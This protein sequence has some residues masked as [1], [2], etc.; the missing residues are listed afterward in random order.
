MDQVHRHA[1]DVDCQQAAPGKFINAHEEGRRVHDAAIDEKGHQESVNAQGQAFC[2]EQAFLV[3][4]PREKPDQSHGEHLPR[5]PRPL[6]KEEVADQHRDCPHQESGFAPKG[7]AADDDDG[8]D[9]FEA[10]HH[11][12]SCPSRTGQ[13]CHGRQDDHLPCLGFSPLKY[14]EERDQR[15]D[16]DHHADE[17]VDPASENGLQEGTRIVGG[18]P[19]SDDPDGDGD[20]DHHKQEE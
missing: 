3:E 20:R 2:R 18:T 17:V 12:E 7:D 1:G 5:G 10:G 16:H 9:R 15:I 13:G 14:H 11:E 4:D 8:N 19:K 6:P